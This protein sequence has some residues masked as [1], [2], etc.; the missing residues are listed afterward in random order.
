ML[1]SVDKWAAWA[2]GLE[3]RVDW[4]AWAHGEKQAEQNNTYPPLSFVEPMFKRRLSQLSRMV[5][6][7]GNELMSGLDDVRVVFASHYGEIG[8]QYKISRSIIESGEVAPASFSLSVFNT[9][10]ALLSIATKNHGYST[11]L[12]GGASAFET[13]LLDT[14]AHLHGKSNAPVVLIVAD[15]LMPEEYNPL[16]PGR[17]QPHAFGFLVSRGDRGLLIDAALAAKA[18]AKSED[19]VSA[20]D[21]LKSGSTTGGLQFLSW[22]LRADKTSDFSSAGSSARWTFKWV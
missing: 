18:R 14:V 5:L 12:F 13:A 22:L 19:S 4:I 6:E 15:E 11:A 1:I 8:Q 10:V 3:S 2:P 20:D 7:V 16:I 17:N 21:A 9:P